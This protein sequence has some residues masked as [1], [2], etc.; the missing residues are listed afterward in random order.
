VDSAINVS[1][2]PAQLTLK[3]L[4]ARHLVFQFLANSEEHAGVLALVI[5]LS[6]TGLHE[7]RQILKFLP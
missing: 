2:L 4:K 6:E 5:Y 1:Q 3:F 7:K